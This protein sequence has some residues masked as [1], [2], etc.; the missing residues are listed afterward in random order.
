VSGTARGGAIS[1]AEITRALLARHN[2]GSES[3][4]LKQNARGETQVE[5]TAVAQ[6]GERLVDAAARALTV[7]ENLRLELQPGDTLL[8]DLQASVKP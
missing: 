2:G 8:A 5:V 4:T 1:L 7:Y 3:V 6:E